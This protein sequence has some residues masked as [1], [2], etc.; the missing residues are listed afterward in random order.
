MVAA[1]AACKTIITASIALKWSLFKKC[2]EEAKAEKDWEREVP[3]ATERSS[4][5]TSKESRNRRSVD[6]PVVEELNAFPV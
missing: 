3:S 4:G 6:L 2:Q 1:Y 5:I